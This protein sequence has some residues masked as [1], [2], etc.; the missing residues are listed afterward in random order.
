MPFISKSY[1]SLPI[2]DFKIEKNKKLTLKI[3]LNHSPIAVGLTVCG[4]GEGGDFHHSDSYR[5]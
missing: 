4:F 3:E 5:N 1:C 2:F